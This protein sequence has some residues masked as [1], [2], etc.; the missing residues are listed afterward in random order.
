MPMMALMLLAPVLP[1]CFP[2]LNLGVRDR[3]DARCQPFESFELSFV[4]GW[5][6]RFHIYDIMPKRL[7]EQS[8]LDKIPTPFVREAPNRL[9]NF[10][11]DRVASNGVDVWPSFADYKI[12]LKQLPQMELGRFLSLTAVG[13]KCLGRHF[14]LSRQQ[15]HHVAL[16]RE[17]RR[18][19]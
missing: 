18:S 10:A 4:F 12:R 6:G 19:T 11:G 16:N 7:L 15:R 13:G 14:A 8:T 17:D 9:K 1:F 5:L 3:H 2:L